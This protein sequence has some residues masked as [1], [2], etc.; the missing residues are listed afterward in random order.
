MCVCVCVCVCDIPNVDIF[1]FICFHNGRGDRGNGLVH[2]HTTG[3]VK[4]L[5]I[6]RGNW[7]TALLMRG[8]GG[9]GEL[10]RAGFNN[11][12]LF[13]LLPNLFCNRFL[14]KK[15]I[16]L[17]EGASSPLLKGVHPLS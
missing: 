14:C 2:L 17:A 16:P 12:F 9:G 5:A 13:A 7:L 10:G 4:G 15:Y 6:C 3:G 8:G 1:N 11:K